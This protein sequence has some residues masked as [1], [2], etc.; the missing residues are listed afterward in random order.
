[1]AYAALGPV[2][3][4]SAADAGLA[5]VVQPATPDVPSLIEAIVDWYASTGRTD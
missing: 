3:A 5:V 4:A 1:M 2:T